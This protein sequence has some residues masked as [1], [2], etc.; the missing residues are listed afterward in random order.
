MQ[1][2]TVESFKGHGM[3]VGLKGTCN[4]LKTVVQLKA[5]SARTFIRF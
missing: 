2:L 5:T 3:A 4:D 1:Y